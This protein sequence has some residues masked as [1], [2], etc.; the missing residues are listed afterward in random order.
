MY[1]EILTKAI[2]AKGEKEITNQNDITI[3]NKISKVLGCWIINHN[4]NLYIE[5]QKIFVKGSY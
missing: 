3:A 1:R 5:N 2:I 4:Y